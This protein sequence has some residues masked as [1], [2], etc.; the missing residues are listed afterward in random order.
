MA[1]TQGEIWHN[2]LIHPKIGTDVADV[3]DVAWQDP[4]YYIWLL[5]ISG[6]AQ[7]ARDN[8]GVLKEATVATVKFHGTL[9][10]IS[11]GMDY[12]EWS[13][14]HWNLPTWIFLFWMIFWIH[15]DVLDISR[16]FAVYRSMPSTAEFLSSIQ[17]VTEVADSF[18]PGGLTWGVDGQSFEKS[19]IP[20]AQPPVCRPA[21]AVS[22][23]AS[24]HLQARHGTRISEDEKT[25]EK[26]RTAEAWLRSL[27]CPDSWRRFSMTTVC[28]YPS[29]LRKKQIPTEKHSI[30]YHHIMCWCALSRCSST[31]TYCD[32]GLWERAADHPR[33]AESPGATE[34]R[35]GIAWGE[36][37]RRGSSM[38]MS[39]CPA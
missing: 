25:L 30:T 17:A 1:L 20:I 31:V 6:P 11:I 27:G 5:D 9:L 34:E 29:W 15:Q 28:F 32:S 22:L 18:V 2:S 8:W 33:A 3:A 13:C 21:I 36:V 23:R 24:K 12:D 26:A 10:W 35:R 39:V 38:S 16:F 7:E 4:T 14:A 37:L 19:M